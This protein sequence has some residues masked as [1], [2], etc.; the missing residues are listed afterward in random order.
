MPKQ[1]PNNRN[2]IRIINELREYLFSDYFNDW[3]NNYQDFTEFENAIK[4]KLKTEISIVLD[5]DRDIAAIVEE[6]FAE[7][8]KIKEILELD[9]QAGYSG[10]PAA[11]GIDEIILCYPGFFAIAVHR[12]AHFMDKLNIPLFPR[13]MSNYAHSKT[14]IDIHPRATIGKHF[15]IDHGTG[16]V[17]GETTIVGDYVKIYQGVTLG[18]LSTK[19]GQKLA[20][21]KRHPTIEDNV[22]IYAGATILG[23]NTVIGHDSTIG[24]NTFVIESIPANTQIRNNY[25]IQH[26]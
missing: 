8:P 11:T 21:I 4:E 12:I 25:Q 17:I 16:V 22:T 5:D 23:G 9:A 3:Q 18:G 20:G 7:L 19:G 14:G 6:L 24:G 2:V 10:D 15:F 13:M 1:F 26:Q